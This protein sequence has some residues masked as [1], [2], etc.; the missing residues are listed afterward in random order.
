MDNKTCV[1]KIQ[2]P[3]AFGKVEDYCGRAA[4]DVDSHGRYLCR[5]HYNAWLKKQNKSTPKPS[6]NG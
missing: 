1:K 3:F 6:H 5:K 2:S 4:T